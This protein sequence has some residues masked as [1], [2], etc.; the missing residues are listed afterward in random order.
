MASSAV[1]T[2][3]HIT[4]RPAHMKLELEALTYDRFWRFGLLPAKKNYRFC[5]DMGSSILRTAEFKLAHKSFPI[6]FFQEDGDF[7]CHAIL[8]L[9]PE[10][11]LA[12]NHKNEWRNK[13]YIPNELQNYPFGLIEIEKESKGK[14]VNS[15][16]LFDNAEQTTFLGIDSSAEMIVS[17]QD[18]PLA[19]QLFQSDGSITPYVEHVL[20]DFAELKQ[21]QLDTASFI[22]AIKANNLLVERTVKLHFKDGTTLSL[23]GF[24][25]V[26][27][28]EF[29]KLSSV[30]VE[31]WKD[32]GYIQLLENH[33]ES[34]KMWPSLILLHERHLKSALKA[35]RAKTSTA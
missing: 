10:I 4:L 6:V 12:I 15:V 30:T 11:N 5:S 27:K 1:D 32:Q 29:N 8:G 9:S 16:S 31:R 28:T 20:N 24:Y 34:Q 19:N 22:S 21:K 14:F 17:M 25:T 7:T 35:L 18:E 2:Q 26:S 33:W 3:P 23:N 13:F